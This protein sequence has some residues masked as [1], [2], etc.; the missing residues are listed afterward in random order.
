MNIVGFAARGDIVGRRVRVGWEFVPAS[1]ETLA[2]IPSVT[3]RRKQRDYAY[4]AAATP[5]PYL[6]YD[7][8]SFPPA[9]VSGA[10]TVT[11]LDGW[12]KTVDGERILFE[13]I[14][15]AVAAG[16]RFVEILRRTTATVFDLNGTALRQRVEI[17]DTGSLPG[18]LQANQVYY[19]QLF[20]VNLPAGGDAAAP[21]RD[22]AMVTDSYGQ[23]RALY[24]ALPEIYRRHDVV[25]GP[26]VPGVGSVPELAP[27]F[28]QL[29]RFIDPFGIALDSLRGTA[30]GLRGL[31]DLDRVDGKF[32]ATLAQWIGWDLS[33]DIEIPLQRNEIKTA[34]RLYRLVGTLPGLRVLVTQ[35]TGWFT[36]VAEFA[37]NI[38]LSNQ[39]PKRNLFAITLDA[40]GQNWHGV[41]DAAELLGFAAA[42]QA[43]GG[44]AGS[45]AT[46]TGTVAEPFAL[47]PGMSL[48]LAVDGLLPASIRFGVQDFAD[49]TQAKAVEIAAVISRV[50]PDVNATANGGRL[51]IASDTVGSNSLLQIVPAPTSLLSLDHASNG[52]LAAGIDSLGRVRLFY[53]AWETPTQPA[54]GIVT[55][56]GPSAAD[57]GNYVLRRIHYKT[58]VDGAWRDAEP[59]YTNRVTPQADPAALVLPDD[60]IWVA[61]L[62]N[63]LTTA[64]QLRWSLGTAQAALPAQLSSRKSEPFAL[65]DGAVLT[66][67]GHWSGG[68]V[69]TVHQADFTNLATASAAELVTAMNAQLNH[70]RAARNQNGSIGL[71]TI[72]GG[73]TAKL[74]I[75]LRHSTTARALGFDNRTAIGVPGSWDDRIDWSPPLDAVSVDAGRLA[76]V[77]AVNDP[78]GGVRLAWASHYAGIWRIES[79]QW[80]DR[81]LIGTA[82]GAYVRDLSGPWAAISGLP[83]PDIRA[84]AVDATGTA[85]I[86]TGA[87]VSLR[88]PDGTIGAFAPALPSPD[89]R[90]IVLGPDG[91]AWIAT[92]A[93]IAICTPGGSVTIVNA[94]GGLPSNDVRALALRRDGTLWVATAAGAARR[95]ASGALQIFTTA[96]GLPSNITQGVALDSGGNVYLATNGGLAIL[97]AAGGL[98][99]VDATSGLAAA[100]ARAVAMAADG[101]LWVATAAG[102]SQRSPAG[103]WQAIDSGDG[104]NS[105]DTRSVAVG[106]DGSAWVG[107]AAGISAITPGGTV[108]NLDLIGGGQPNPAGRAAQTG[109]SAVMELA[110][111]GGGNREPSLAIDANHRI[112]LAWS[113]RVGVGTEQES[114]G[115][116]YRIYDPT[117]L[118]WAPD[119][120]L[121]GPPPAGRSSDRTPGLLALPTG[122]RVFFASDRNG[123]F[124]LWSV[125]ISLAG[126]I[127]ALTALPDQASS[128]LA[129]CPVAFGTTTWLLY[130]SD[131]NVSLAQ[132]GSSPQSDGLLA[133]QR[134]PDNGTVRR[135]S[136]SVA[137]DLGDL[138]RLRTRRT[139]GDMLCYTPNRPDGA[140]TLVNDEYYTR[141]TVGLY[142]SRAFQGADL[143]QQEADRLSEM[144]QRFL[145]INLRA[146]IILVETPD[147]E[148]VYP[149]AVGPTD[150]YSDDYP[151]VSYYGPI[152]DSSAAAMPGLV[153][154]HSNMTDNVSANPAD[155]T[156]LRRRTYF[157]PL[158]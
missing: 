78:A 100:D 82:N 3:L 45:A 27:N 101:T 97:A 63:P 33:I 120:V 103:T 2:D 64:T 106:P 11:D 135:Y 88:H 114:W 151:F 74:A 53:E 127:G 68:D 24:L 58:F 72:T 90:D 19:Y 144:L 22:A 110:S 38:A 117:A 123:G 4:P 96:N 148:F 32:L 116:H 44:S 147:V 51:V 104:L 29:R 139:F 15:V 156:T 89:I 37:Q 13:S 66:L 77:A 71:S 80:N 107:T 26:D 16:G 76:E 142:V 157:P 126:A 87:G 83:S 34:S 137:A 146:L 20:S 8:N 42:N 143:T 46:L 9:P 132:T 150:S 54:P 21:Y 41:D 94:A 31:H 131:A 17:L 129:P 155:L 95:A 93:G 149:N 84:L 152:P 141:G 70:V 136:G 158:Q 79:A 14:S 40:D 124:S 119:I 86:G 153:V 56:T 115:L 43:A 30:E 39:P 1:G 12:E 81:V 6:V 125:D 102:V 133:S 62:D 23:N 154:L 109:W 73:D 52:R 128:E 7:T 108:A 35:Y 57:T 18:A 67:I 85:W 111:G 69:Y 65:T 91:T 60:R 28:G 59:I 134:V 122:M 130:R 5:D 113:Q 55:T 49:I 92:A 98:T 10:L 75:D 99:T 50:L 105:N 121:T 112:W 36:Q 61:W 140:G 138:N 25:I 145:P 48:T 47:R 118:T